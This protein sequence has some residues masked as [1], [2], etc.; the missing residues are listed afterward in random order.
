MGQTAE[1]DAI[2]QEHQVAEIEGS[3]KDADGKH[4]DVAK[5]LLNV[6]D[7]QGDV[8]PI[9]IPP[10]IACEICGLY[11]HATRDCRRLI[12]EICGM[13]NHMAYDCKRCLP[14]NLGS[15]LCAAQVED[16]SFFYIDELV[17]PRIA[18]EKDSTAI[19]SVINGHATS[20]Q[21]EQEFMG[22]VGAS[23]LRWTARQLS[24][25][26]FVMIFPSA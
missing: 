14:W 24:E 4:D 3:Q 2:A 6:P 23:T 5:Q 11:N 17:D 18:R 13:N 21:I 22:L 19:I 9:P 7:Q 26:R 1:N 15:E 12:C 10:R 8:A 20:K 16:Q 25:G